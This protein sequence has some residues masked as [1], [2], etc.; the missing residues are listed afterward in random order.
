M[1]GVPTTPVADLEPALWERATRHPFLR[2]VGRGRVDNFEVWLGQDVVFVADLIIFQA[3]LVAR[4]PRPAQ[5]VLAAGVVGL[6][7]ELDWFDELATTSGVA[8]PAELLAPTRRYRELLQDLDQQP[9]AHA[10]AALWLLERVYL[11]GW[12]YA[13][14]CGAGG[15]Y[16]AALAH[17]T[18]PDFARY[19][20]ALEELTQD[21]RHG[22]TA[23]AALLRQVL[24]AEAA[25]WDMTGSGR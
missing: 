24:Q 14:S 13:A 12:R 16:A 21:P 7:A 22:G 20:A 11:E 9:Y 10:V 3:R 5:R 17:W 19:V 15:P 2:D 18:D 4:A 23:P 25:F 1:D 8:L 6:I